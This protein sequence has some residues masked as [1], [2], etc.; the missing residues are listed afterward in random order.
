MRRVLLMS[1]IILAG[2]SASHA[3]YTSEPAP[4]MLPAGESV[5]VDDGTCGPGR[6]KKVTSGS[7]RSLRTGQHV[8][9]GVK[10]TRTCIKRP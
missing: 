2:I 10:R 3:Q 9:G 8:A 4:G 1:A 7:N 6:I 5:L